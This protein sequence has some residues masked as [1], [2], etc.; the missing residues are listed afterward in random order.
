MR[1]ALETSGSPVP[2]LLDAAVKRFPNHPAMDFLGRRWNDRQLAAAVGRTAAG[3]QGLGV[4]KGTRGALCLPNW[5]KFETKIHHNHAAIGLKFNYA[6]RLA[7]PTHDL[8][9]ITQY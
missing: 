3:L 5:A 4:G 9:H 7:H 1:D 6:V 8:A 2:A